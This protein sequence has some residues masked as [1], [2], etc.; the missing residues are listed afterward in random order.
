MMGIEIRRIPSWWQHPRTGV[1]EWL[2]LYDQSYDE[3][4]IEYS[5]GLWLWQRNLHPMQIEDPA[6]AIGSYEDWYGD[7]PDPSEYRGISWDEGEATA[8]I[9]YENVSAGTPLSPAFISCEELLAWMLVSNYAKDIVAE[10]Q[11][12]GVYDTLSCVPRTGGLR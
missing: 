1:G 8:W 3:A 2:P 5:Y 4:Y 9:L 7:F 10:I 11:R 6:G 12:T